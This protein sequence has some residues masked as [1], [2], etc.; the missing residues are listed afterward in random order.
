M[1]APGAGGALLLDERLDAAGQAHRLVLRLAAAHAEPALLLEEDGEVLGA[2][3]TL[4]VRTV[5]QR[6]GRALDAEVPLGGDCLQLAGAVL[7]RLRHRAAVDAIGRDYLVWDEAGQ[8][9]LAAL[10]AAVAA[11]LRHLAAA[12]RG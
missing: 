8:D 2:L 11:P 1:P 7:R 4:A 9:P 5:M 6:Y 12:R 3:S 10:C